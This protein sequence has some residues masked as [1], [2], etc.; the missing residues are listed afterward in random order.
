[1]ARAYA[2]TGYTASEL[3]NEG[4]SPYDIKKLYNGPDKGERIYR[5]EKVKV[6]RC[7]RYRDIPGEEEGDCLWWVDGSHAVAFGAGRDGMGEEG[8][9]GRYVIGGGGGK[10]K[11]REGEG[12]T[13]I[14]RIYHGE[15]QKEEDST[16]RNSE[17]SQPPN[18]E[19]PLPP[20]SS[21]TTPINPITHHPPSPTHPSTHILSLV[22]TP[23][24][25]SDV[26]PTPPK[27]QVSDAKLASM[28]EWM[29]PSGLGVS[30]D[31]LRDILMPTEDI[32][33][34]QNMLNL[35]AGQVRALRKFHSLP[36]LA[37]DSDGIGEENL[38][39]AKRVLILT[40]R[41]R[42]TDG[43]AALVTCIANEGTSGK[44]RQVIAALDEREDCT[45]KNS[46][47]K[48]VVEMSMAGRLDEDTLF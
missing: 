31:K 7:M 9:E 40:P 11:G 5:A 47:W 38:P 21:S 3:P 13:H 35:T 22:L 19:D 30:M 39:V 20:T 23:N 37:S 1:M 45:V 44:A 42:R 41:D 16:A 12:F 26:P 48:G 36:V 28:Y 33:D 27:R 4:P 24:P 32:T 29:K 46:P 17:E 2:Q 8:W 25:V 14:I 18:L 34:R 6:E 15:R 43:M 10:G